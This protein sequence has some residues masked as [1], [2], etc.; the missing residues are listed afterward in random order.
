MNSLPDNSSLP[1]WTR[2][3]SGIRTSTFPNPNRAAL[4]ISTEKDELGKDGYHSFPPIDDFEKPFHNESALE[5]YRQVVGRR[6]KERLEPGMSFAYAG[7]SDMSDEPEDELAE[8]YDRLDHDQQEQVYM[9][10]LDLTAVEHRRARLA[11]YTDSGNGL[12]SLRITVSDIGGSFPI[13][14]TAND[15]RLGCVNGTWKYGGFAGV[16]KE[17]H[18]TVA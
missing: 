14:S 17:L 13:T 12:N 4:K 10:Q 15:P 2:D 8:A 1:G 6:D 3:P 16:R 11:L 5:L 18:L 7:F 9:D